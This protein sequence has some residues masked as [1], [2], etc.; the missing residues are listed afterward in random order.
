M[1][2]AVLDMSWKSV[3][4]MMKVELSVQLHKSPFY[5]SVMCQFWIRSNNHKW[6]YLSMDRRLMFLPMSNGFHS[7]WSF[8]ICDQISPCFIKSRS[9]ASARLS[10]YYAHWLQTHRQIWMKCFI[11]KDISAVKNGTDG[12]TDRRHIT[13]YNISLASQS[14]NIKVVG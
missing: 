12:Q 10:T 13:K 14:I 8:V 9:T 4:C 3:D 11:C 5:G 7:Q 1:N 2:I 6:I